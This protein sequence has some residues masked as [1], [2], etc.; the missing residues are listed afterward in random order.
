VFAV[1]RFD[2]ATGREVLIAFNTST[3]PVVEQLQVQPASRRFAS[4]LGRCATDATAAGVVTVQLAPL[5]YMVCEAL[6]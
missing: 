6:P 2:P 3:V 1:S 5:D 4:L